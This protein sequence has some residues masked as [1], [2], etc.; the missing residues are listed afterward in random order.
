MSRSWIG[1]FVVIVAVVTGLAVPA[2][3]QTAQGVAPQA[4]P[5]ESVF[6]VTAAGFR[7]GERVGYWL[8]LPDGTIVRFTNQLG[9]DNDGRIT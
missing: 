2:F 5:P 3:A 6:T 7:P 9:A 1:I 4:A 8:N